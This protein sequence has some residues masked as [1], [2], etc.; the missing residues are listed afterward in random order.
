VAGGRIFWAQNAATT[1]FYGVRLSAETSELAFFA[2]PAQGKTVIAT[3]VSSVTGV[4]AFG[5]G[6]SCRFGQYSKYIPRPAT[7]VAVAT[8]NIGADPSGINSIFGHVRD[9]R[10]Y[11]SAL[12]NEQIKAIA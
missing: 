3:G 7:S 4:I 6:L 8:I 5:V 11:L 10:G 12:S 2:G 1:L 9:L